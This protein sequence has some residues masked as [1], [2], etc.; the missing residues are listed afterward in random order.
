MQL[1]FGLLNQKILPFVKEYYIFVICPS[2]KC[3]STNQSRLFRGWGVG[4]GGIKAMGVTAMKIKSAQEAVWSTYFRKARAS[5]I[6]TALPCK[7][8]L[9]WCSFWV[10]LSAKLHS[11]HDKGQLYKTQRKLPPPLPPNYFKDYLFITI[12][13]PNFM[14]QAYVIP[15]AFENKWVICDRP[16]CV[17]T[18]KKKKPA[19][20]SSLLVCP[21][22]V[23]GLRWVRGAAGWVRELFVCFYLAEVSLEEVDLILPGLQLSNAYQNVFLSYII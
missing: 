10:L 8:C 3:G 6:G 7:P 23:R 18:L 2:E 5:A 14:F 12:Q 4:G 1:K 13:L 22:S 9:R 15:L 11:F 17:S 20:H 16:E 19:G 21:S